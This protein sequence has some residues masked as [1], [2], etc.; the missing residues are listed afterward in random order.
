MPQDTQDPF[1]ER[2]KRSTPILYQPYMNPF[3]KAQGRGIEIPRSKKG[4]SKAEK[5]LIAGTF[6]ICTG[7]WVTLAYLIYINL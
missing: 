5:L 4:M 1:V 2:N 7:V 3:K 6:G